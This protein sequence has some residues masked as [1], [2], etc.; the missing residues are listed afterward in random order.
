MRKLKKVCPFCGSRKV[1]EY[2]YGMPAM[3]EELEK[4]LEKNKVILAGCCVSN[5]DP[6]YH[7][8]ECGKDFGKRR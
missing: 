6:E 2:L 5:V 4:N 3:S 8:N 7:C 1:A